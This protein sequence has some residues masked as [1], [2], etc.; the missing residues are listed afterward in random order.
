[1]KKT[2]IKV[3]TVFSKIKVFFVRINPFKKRAKLSLTPLKIFIVKN[4]L[5]LGGITAVAIA[6]FG[7]YYLKNLFIAATV[8]GSLI[9]RVKVIKELEKRGGSSILETL[10][11]EK[12][13][14]QDAA[15]KN[16]SVSKEDVDS[17]IASIEANLKSQSQDLKT[18]LTAQGMTLDDLKNQ[19]TLQKLLEK[20]L[21]DKITVTDEEITKYMTDN[22]VTLPEGTDQENAKSIIKQQIIQEKLGQEIQPLLDT[23]KKAAKINIF[24]KY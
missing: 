16:I 1:M 5:I 21:A 6:F 15:K 9:S 10:I 18:A 8:N 13:I 20:M 2:K 4:K 11:T 22:K 19:I 24:V 17:A 12:L 3:N 14:K 23:L 7:G